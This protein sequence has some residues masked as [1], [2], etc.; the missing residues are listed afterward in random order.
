MTTYDSNNVFAKIEDAQTGPRG[1][2]LHFEIPA[3]AHLL[4][5]KCK[6]GITADGSECTHVGIAGAVKQTG[7][8]AYEPA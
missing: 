6:Q 5:V 7:K 2:Q 8:S 4:H 1:L 3:V